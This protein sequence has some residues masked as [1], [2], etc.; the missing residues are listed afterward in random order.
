MEVLVRDALKEDNESI[1][2]L[3]DEL[4]YSMTPAQVSRWIEGIQA[5]SSDRL[6]VATANGR[7]V[8]VASL[9]ILP[10]FPTGG[11]I[12]RIS[13]LVVSSHHRGQGIGSRLIRA[14][15]ETARAEGCQGVEITTSVRRQDAHVFY[16]RRG[17]R[18]T[19][20]RFFKS[21]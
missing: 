8:G 16:E 21:F 6:I 15:E 5:Q 20:L 10:Y 19:S 2:Q 9:H 13:A 14:A 7:C 3:L 18:R 1:A 4:G 12:C 11:N 17:Y